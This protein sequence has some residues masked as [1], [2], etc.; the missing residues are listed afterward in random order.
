MPIY[1]FNCP[2]CNTNF[3]ELIFGEDIPACPKCGNG[4]THKLLSCATLHSQ[5][6]SRV[7]QQV[8]F[9][10]SGRSGC[11]SCAGGNCSSCGS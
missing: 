4:E 2:K 5:A 6:P 9:P 11:G 7:G 10:T 8:S 1:E 3:E